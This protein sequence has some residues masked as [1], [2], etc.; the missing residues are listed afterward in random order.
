MPR[1]KSNI[2]LNLLVL[3]LALGLVNSQG[4]FFSNI[5]NM[6]FGGSRP[7]GPPPNQRQPGPQQSGPPQQFGQQP[8]PQQFQSQPPQQQ[9]QSQPPQQQFQSQQQFGQQQQN[10]GGN[11]PVVAGNG[12]APGDFLS[13]LFSFRLVFVY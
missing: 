8:A 9:F 12:A 11:V 5:R 1:S 6:V 7:A 10:L 2:G 13:R 4:G 3:A